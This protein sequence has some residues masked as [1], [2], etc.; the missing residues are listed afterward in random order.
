[1]DIDELDIAIVD[2]VRIAPRGS[3]R[4]LG[5]AL[6]IDPSTVSRRWTRM[7][8]SGLAW[9]TAHPSG[10]ATPV[11]AL[12]EIDCEPGR[13]I[14]V[15]RGLAGDREAATIKVTSGARDVMVLVQTLSLEALSSYL[16][17]LVPRVAG[18]ARVRS[19]ILTRSTLEASRWRDGA[20][21]SE[22]QR[23]LGARMAVGSVTAEVLDE[24]DHRIVGALHENGRMS[25]ERLA[26]RSGV[27]ALAVRRRLTRLQNGGLVTLRCD[28]S[29]E[30]SGRSVWAMYFG[31]LDVQDLR[32]A[33]ERLR[34]LHGVR[35]A[36]FAA[37]PFNVVV[38]AWLHSTAEVHDFEW[39]MGQEL[40]ELRILDRTVVLQMTKLLGRVLDADG[41]VVGI[42]PLLSDDVQ[43]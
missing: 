12:V 2:A 35:A 40:P 30:L 29:H 5:L 16:L 26:E 21:N 4:D 33:E 39:R 3:W 14:D 1:M 11:C 27:G 17:G 31:S 25:F 43:V 23:R 36:S 10:A 28:V 38:D 13:S 42:V 34:T 7:E 15:A 8:A 41:R 22:Q 37:G 6:G 19:H 9:V 32:S 20:L 18:I 24:V